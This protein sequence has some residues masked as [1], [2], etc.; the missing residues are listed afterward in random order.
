MKLADFLSTGGY[1]I[2]PDSYNLSRAGLAHNNH[3][4]PIALRRR[5]ILINQYHQLKAIS[6]DFCALYFRAY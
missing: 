1:L 3:S 2:L 4:V 5:R 6:F